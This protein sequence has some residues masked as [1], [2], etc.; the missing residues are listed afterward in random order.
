VLELSTAT[1]EH[2]GLDAPINPDTVRVDDRFVGSGYGYPTAGTM[3]AIEILARDEAIILDP[4]YTGKAMSGL[5][6]HAREGR[7]DDDD[8]VV[9]LH[10]G[11]A[12]ALFAYSTE[13]ASAVGAPGA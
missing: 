8:V 7:F 1:L 4:V 3:E 12:P 9:F 11:G 13:T 10:T 5:I 2:L 6:A